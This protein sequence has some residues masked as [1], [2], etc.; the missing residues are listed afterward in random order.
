M[1]EKRPGH[2]N[3]EWTIGQLK[4]LKERYTLKSPLATIVSATGHTATSVSQKMK[5]LGMTDGYTPR[6]RGK[7][8]LQMPRIIRIPDRKCCPTCG[9][10]ALPTTGLGLAPVEWRIY[11][12]VVANPDIVT[13]DLWDAVW[14]GDDAG[15]SAAT[16]LHRLIWR[17]NQ[18]LAV[19]DMAIRA[20]GRGRFATWRVIHI[21][22]QLAAE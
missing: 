1:S 17:A 11:R 21:Q 9:Q 22:E 8:R 4:V 20:T 5:A 14:P 19:N 13:A 16:G 3:V 2:R 12:T 7:R 10:P 18:K 6:V 15:P